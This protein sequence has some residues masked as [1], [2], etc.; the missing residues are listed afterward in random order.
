VVDAGVVASKGAYAHHGN[1]DSLF[2]RQFLAPQRQEIDCRRKGSW[3]RRKLSEFLDLLQPNACLEFGV[4]GIQH[5]EHLL[6]DVQHGL[7]LLLELVSGL[8]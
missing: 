6:H 4:L 1:T 2:G 7:D 3:L 5:A 8:G